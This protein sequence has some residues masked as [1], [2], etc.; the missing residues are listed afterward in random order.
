MWEE[1]HMFSQYVRQESHANVL[2]A[3]VSYCDETYRIERPAYDHYVIEYT[4]AGEGALEVGGKQYDIRAGDVYFL[5]RGSAHKYYCKGKSWTKI[6][7]VADGEAVEALFRIYL[8]GKPDV[9]RGFDICSRM[10]RMIEFAK[11]RE[12]PYDEM[13][14]KIVLIL[15]EILMDVNLCP[16]GNGERLT[17]KIRDFIDGN[18]YR[19]LML[20][21]LS[22]RFHYSKNHI[23]NAFR[24]EFGCTPHVYYE[25]QKMIAAAELLTGTSESI[26]NIS[27][28]LGFDSPQYFSKRFKKHFG[29]TPAQYRKEPSAREQP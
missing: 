20:D 9:L 11:N 3:G 22:E 15:H 14:K 7:V 4:M 23:I 28:R 2:M 27:A 6:W 10:Q 19:P 16:D 8:K 17:R 25:K 21:D 5:Y 29:V 24:N 26:G 12:I 18:L 13:V 1:I